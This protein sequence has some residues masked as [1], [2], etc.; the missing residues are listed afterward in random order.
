MRGLRAAL[1]EAKNAVLFAKN[2]LFVVATDFAASGIQR[3][4]V[5]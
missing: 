5:M 1:I 2:I 4:C 3:W